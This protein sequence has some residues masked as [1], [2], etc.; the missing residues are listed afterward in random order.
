MTSSIRYLC[1]TDLTQSFVLRAPAGSGKTELLIQRYLKALLDCTDPAE[2]LALT[3]TQKSAAEI[4]QRVTMLLRGATLSSQPLT[5]YLVQAVKAKM[6]SGVWGAHVCERLSIF[7]LDAYF[8]KIYQLFCENHREGLSQLITDRPEFHRK[9]AQSFLLYFTHTNPHETVL[10]FIQKGE[11]R[12]YTLQDR[13]AQLFT[14]RDRWAL[15]Q[16]S[17]APQSWDQFF[18]QELEALDSLLPSQSAY[19]SILDFLHTYCEKA[20]LQGSKTQSWTLLSLALL[21]ERGLWRKSFRRSEGIP[22][23]KDLHPWHSQEDRKSVIEDLIALQEALRFQ[24]ALT[25]FLRLLRA[26]SWDQIERSKGTL[27][28]DLMRLVCA[29]SDVEK[30]EQGLIDFQSITHKVSDLFDDPMT[31]GAIEAYC[32]KHIAHLFLDE[33]QDLSW[34]Q[35]KIVHH[36]IQTFSY[37]P[38]SFFIVG[39]PQQAIYYF[40]GSDL[41]VFQSFESL[42]CPGLTVRSDHLNENYRSTESLVHFVNAWSAHVFGP[43][44][45]ALFGIDKAMASIA[46]SGK[47]GGVIENRLYDSVESEAYAVAAYVA[48]RHKENPEETIAILARDRKTLRP[49]ASW[50]R[51]L[52]IQ[53]DCAELENI[54]DQELYHDGTSF[55]KVFLEPEQR[56]HWL[57]FFRT[58]W[59]RSS[60]QDLESIYQQSVASLWDI[61]RGNLSPL[62][63]RDLQPFYSAHDL[64]EPYKGR[65]G[66]ED[67]IMRL[68]STLKLEDFLVPFE[69]ALMQELMKAFHRLLKE[70]R[71]DWAALDSWAKN[72][73]LKLDRPQGPVGL[74]TIH[75]SKGLEFDTVFMPNCAARLPVRDAPQAVFTRLPQGSLSGAKIDEPTDRFDKLL[76]LEKYHHDYESQ[77]LLYVA[78]TR[79]KHNLI[80]SANTEKN[81]TRS[82]Y[83]S[84]DFPGNTLLPLPQSSPVYLPHSV[85]DAAWKTPLP[86]LDPL[87]WDKISWNT[88]ALTW[89]ALP[90]YNLQDSVLGKLWHTFLQKQ[91]LGVLQWSWVTKDLWQ[92]WWHAHGGHPEDYEAPLREF[93]KTVVRLKNCPIFR[94]IFDEAHRQSF[95]E[96]E[97][98]YL[99]WDGRLATIRVDRLVQKP[100]G[101]WWLIDWK[102]S[103]QVLTRKTQLLHQLQN[104]KHV[105]EKIYGPTLQIGIY[106]L[107]NQTYFDLHELEEAHDP[108]EPSPK[109]SDCVR[110][111][112]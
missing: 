6:D 74:W 91:S 45:S 60:Y 43:L 12:F 40:R 19:T 35:A 28:E 3:F 93:G 36:L 52:Q 89:K 31:Q 46:C 71:C 53:P 42:T 37:L 5:Q 73:P 34:S 47:T 68:C 100:C 94:K 67:Y 101:T 57:L 87:S 107:S 108:I 16:S 75:K 4:R 58:R 33:S 59:I 62:L 64:F 20:P 29:W 98:T 63:Q 65:I 24:P 17:P 32:E 80:L 82:F 39:D 21:T 8:F 81:D 18:Q 109:S 38:K 10:T 22:P 23:E 44:S 14:L 88:T 96:Q 112:K 2:A 15:S 95:T 99:D 97:Y 83:N 102:T 50:L 79:A 110:A 76:A 7:T 103:T 105:L 85:K 111:Q 77:R 26:F 41:S 25:A 104:Y 54:Y 61:D 49:I 1:A 69:R 72:T 9:L 13:I 11:L 48:S 106:I 51:S 78:L 86:P 55:L 27:F 56:E 66:C 90:L 92:R 84:L 30:Q 70:G